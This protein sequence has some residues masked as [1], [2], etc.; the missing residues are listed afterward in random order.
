MCAVNNAQDSSGLYKTRRRTAGLRRLHRYGQEKEVVQDLTPVSVESRLWN[1]ERSARLTEEMI[2]YA[3]LRT[4]APEE[5]AE[6]A[7]QN[8]TRFFLD[9]RTI[10][11]GT[12]EDS[13]PI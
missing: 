9:S 4:E 6:T 11:E 8:Q 13:I 5:G 2:V 12:E 10:V 7:E 3:P 1:G